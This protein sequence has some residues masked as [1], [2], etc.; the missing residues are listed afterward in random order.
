MACNTFIKIAQ[1]CKEEFVIP[2]NKHDDHPG[3]VM[4][5]EPYIYELIRRIPEETNLLDNANKIVFFEAV[6]K[7]NDYKNIA[8]FF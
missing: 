2:H 5:T 4:D 8:L 3:K 6:G 1:N 7:E